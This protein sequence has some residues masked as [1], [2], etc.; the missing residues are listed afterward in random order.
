MFK[1]FKENRL[2]FEFERCEGA[3][4]FRD[5]DAFEDEVCRDDQKDK[6][7]KKGILDVADKG[8]AKLNNAAALADRKEDP[9]ER[10]ADEAS[11][12]LA[13]KEEEQSRAGDLAQAEAVFETWPPTVE[14]NV[15]TNPGLRGEAE[16]QRAEADDEHGERIVAKEGVEK[17]HQA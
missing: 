10:E 8:V 4:Y 7:N 14:S 12:V 3:D 13:R 2:M 5:G 15:D 17:P 1:M 6:P 16:G 9:A 11:K